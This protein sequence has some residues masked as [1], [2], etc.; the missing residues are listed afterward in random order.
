MEHARLDYDLLLPRRLSMKVYH[1]IILDEAHKIKNE[2]SF[3]SHAASHLRSINKILLTGTP[4]QNNMHELWVLLHFLFPDVFEHADLFDAAF[5]RKFG[6]LNFDL[7]LMRAAHKLLQPLML[8]RLKR[9]V[10]RQLPKKTVYTIWCP[11]T[12]M[13]KF[14][15]KQFLLLNQGSI[16]LLKESHVS[17]SVLRCL[18][19]LLMQLRKV[20][21]H[22]YLFPEADGDPTSTDASIVTNSTKMMVLHR[23]IDKLHAQGRKLLVY[24]QFTTMLDV[25]QDYCDLVGHKYLRLD[26]N[27]AS[28]RRK[29]EIQLF[30][31]GKSHAY[32]Y[33]LSTRAGALGITLTGADTVVMMDADWNPT[34]DKQAHDRVH[35]IGQQKEV[36]IYQLLCT[37][38]VE[39]RIF[40]RAQQKVALNQ[41]VLQD[42]FS[43]PED[44]P[45][46]SVT[47]GLVRET[48][49]CGMKQILLADCSSERP[50]TMEEVD[51][52]IED[53]HLGKSSFVERAPPDDV[54]DIKLWDTRS[55]EGK[56]FSTAKEC[57]RCIAEKWFLHQSQE[58][59]KRKS[60][61]TT[62]QIDGFPVKI[63]NRCAQDVKGEGGDGALQV[64]A[65]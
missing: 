64:D 51:Q 46:H 15:Y 18:V 57:F 43:L 11:L 6:G 14:W 2:C 25:I 13:Q 61:P 44:D 40:Q 32:V 39:E 17:S 4:L 36:T 60:V 37:N 62:M 16:A 27:T 30:N 12:T 50:L 10:Q 21:N 7:S 8:R 26:G 49:W 47:R 20:C 5:T 35:R 59:S 28:C 48:L 53:T 63:V 19:N 22:P 24:S 31:S 54:F 1:Y 55:F 29:Y 45:D 23:L 34:W 9:D 58:L 42:D 52:M 3:A 65:G 33:L 38:T 41:I 56:S